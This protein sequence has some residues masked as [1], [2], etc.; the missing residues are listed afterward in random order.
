MQPWS[1]VAIS[2]ILMA[3]SV[4]VASAAIIDPGTPLNRT[5]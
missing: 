3:S 1:I 5:R 2:A 4:A